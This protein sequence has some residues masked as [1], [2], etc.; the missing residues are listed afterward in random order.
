MMSHFRTMVAL[1]AVAGASAGAGVVKLGAAK[2]NTLYES[3]LGD[4]SNGAGQHCFVG[5]TAGNSIRRT[6]IR[7]DVEGAIPDGAAFVGATLTMHMSKTTAGPTWVSLHCALEDWG[8]GGSDAPDDEGRGAPAQ[9]DDATWIY[10]YHDT[11]YWTQ[12]GGR[13]AAAPSGDPVLVDGPGDYAWG[14]WYGPNGDV[15]EWLDG[16][17]PNYGWVMVGDELAS[18]TAKRFDTREN[19]DEAHRPS[20]TL[21]YVPACIGDWDSNGAVDTKDVLGYLNEWAAQAPSA[22]INFSGN[23]DTLDLLVFLN[24]WVAGC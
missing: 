24:A 13:F 3:P 15:S 22:D 4:I 18:G 8:E 16:S 5:V 7:F 2:D 6:V 9:T 12:Q 20:L 11:Y 21:Y 23:I 17:A 19:P 1:V 10:T 14:P